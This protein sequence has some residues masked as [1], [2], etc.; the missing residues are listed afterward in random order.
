M[1]ARYFK[2]GGGGGGGKLSSLVF[3]VYCY[4]LKKRGM[5]ALCVC[6]LTN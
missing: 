3:N 5:F 4:E 1:V 2:G 6:V